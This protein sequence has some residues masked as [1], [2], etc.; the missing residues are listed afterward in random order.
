M[1][2]RVL[3]YYCVTARSLRV[4]GPRNDTQPQN[5]DGIGLDLVAHLVIADEQASHFTVPEIGHPLAQERM[6]LKMPGPGFDLIEDQSCGTRMARGQKSVQPDKITEHFAG[7]DYA[8][9][10]GGK[11]WSVP[12]L[13]IQAST[14]P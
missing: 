2:L 4:L 14:S 5:P 12:R 8:H 9:E 3:Q 13:A 7:P 11:A 6:G 10:G 1:S